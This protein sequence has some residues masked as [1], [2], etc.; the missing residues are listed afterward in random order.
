MIALTSAQRQTIRGLTEQEKFAGFEY[1]HI[2]L[3][4]EAVEVFDRNPE[5]K[6]AFLEKLF[7]AIS[8]LELE[9]VAYISGVFPAELF[10]QIYSKE[11]AL[12]IIPAWEVERFSHETTEHLIVRGTSALYKT[13]L[14]KGRFV[15]D[16]RRCPYTVDTYPKEMLCHIFGAMGC[17][18]TEWG[19]AGCGVR[20]YLA[21]QGLVYPDV[22]ETDYTV[23]NWIHC[24]DV[25]QGDT[26][27]AVVDFINK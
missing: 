6:A 16:P 3:K 22:G 20:G 4:P 17:N 21:S 14:V 26:V 11:V 13:S 23:Y 27:Q 8:L 19:T 2:M 15:C 25:D 1:S 12:G 24:P 5:F 10:Y 18:H 7:L 9:V